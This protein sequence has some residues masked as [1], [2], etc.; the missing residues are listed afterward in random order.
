MAIEAKCPAGAKYKASQEMK[1]KM[2]SFAAGAA[3]ALMRFDVRDYHDSECQ[4]LVPNV[5]LND[6][7]AKFKFIQETQR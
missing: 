5:D 1:A 4:R 2:H 6:F 7:E 3:N